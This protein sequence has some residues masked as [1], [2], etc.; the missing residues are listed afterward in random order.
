MH[1]HK[2]LMSLGNLKLYPLCSRACMHHAVSRRAYG[3]VDS[4]VMSA[5]FAKKQGAHKMKCC[6]IH[7][8]ISNQINYLTNAVSL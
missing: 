3:N 7:F 6:F 8:S 4:D 5:H 2:P 1:A